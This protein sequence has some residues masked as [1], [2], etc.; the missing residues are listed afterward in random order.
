MTCTQ[1]FAVVGPASRVTFACQSRTAAGEPDMPAS[2]HFPHGGIRYSRDNERTFPAQRAGLPRRSDWRTRWPKYSVIASANLAADL[3]PG[4]TLPDEGEILFDG[5][6]AQKLSVSQRKVLGISVIH[7]E[8]N[9]V[10]AMTIV[11]NIFLG[12]EFSLGPGVKR[13]GMFTQPLIGEMLG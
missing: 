5:A 8:L 6:P 4:V 7:Q 13:A 11:Q 3:L 10:A 2:G 12:N 9:L 1:R